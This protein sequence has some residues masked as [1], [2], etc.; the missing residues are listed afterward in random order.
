[1]RILLVEDD[2]DLAAVVALGL[3]GAGYAT[4]VA[5]TSEQAAQHLAGTAYDVACLDL[6]LPDGDGLDLLRRLGRTRT[7]A[8]PIASSCSPP[9]TGST[10]VLRGWTPAPTTISSSPSSSPSCWRGCVRSRAGRTPAAVSCRSGRSRWT[11]PGSAL[12]GQVV[13]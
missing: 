11:S 10:T 12:G 13:N 8:H 6:G 4:D 9:A 2:P 1:M 3:R 5:A 7:C